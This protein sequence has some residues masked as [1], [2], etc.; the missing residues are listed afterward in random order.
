M[1]DDAKV[2]KVSVE[3]KYLEKLEREL[4]ELRANGESSRDRVVKLEDRI[5]N[6]AVAAARRRLLEESVKRRG[7][8]LD[9][10]KAAG[11]LEQLT[12][13]VV[14][15]VDETGRAFVPDGE[16]EKIRG[17][18]KAIISSV[19]P[20]QRVVSPPIAPGEPPRRA[21]RSGVD[22]GN[23]WEA[24]GKRGGTARGKEM[25]AAAARELERD[26]VL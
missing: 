20:Q 5:K 6:E 18:V 26:G 13:D 19:G 15:E 4:E 12:N 16:L 9:V 3:K 24:A 17:Q 2:E 14:A 23:S 11:L 21:R 7:A 22:F 10:V 8:A 1:A 25:I